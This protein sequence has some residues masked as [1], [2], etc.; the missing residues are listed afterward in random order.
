MAVEA[1]KHK[2]GLDKDGSEAGEDS[3]VMSVVKNFNI[4]V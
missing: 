3:S 4:I 2:D 1:E